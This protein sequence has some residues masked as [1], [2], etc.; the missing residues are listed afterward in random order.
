[1]IPK[2]IVKKFKK[3]MCLPPVKRVSKNKEPIIVEVPRKIP[4][5]AF[6][7]IFV[8]LDIFFISIHR[9]IISNKNL[10]GK[11]CGIIK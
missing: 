6:S 10:F 1:V 4:P 5:S 11:K 9:T 2:L 8:S 7:S 3:V